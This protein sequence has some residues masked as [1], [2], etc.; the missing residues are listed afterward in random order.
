MIPG[1][2]AGNKGINIAADGFQ[3]K[4][5]QQI[6]AGSHV[7]DFHSVVRCPAERGW[8]WAAHS[9]Q[10]AAHDL[11]LSLKH[12]MCLSVLT[13]GVYTYNQFNNLIKSKSKK[14]D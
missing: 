7:K 8:Q 3:G 1:F 13:K 10:H 11:H 12:T 5:R 2:V 14:S 9:N 4:I 6:T